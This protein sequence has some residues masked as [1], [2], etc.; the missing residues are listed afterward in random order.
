MK[1]KKKIISELREI[2]T[3]L[4]DENNHLKHR[5]NAERVTFAIAVPKGFYPNSFVGED[6]LKQ[7]AIAQLAYKIGTS[8]WF[9]EKENGNY[10]QLEVTLVR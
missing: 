10:T 4:E 8:G 3:E 9:K 6:Q 2:I 7:D 5:L 1:T